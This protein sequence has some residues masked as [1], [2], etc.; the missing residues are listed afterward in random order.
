MK[1]IL[2]SGSA[3]RRTMLEAAGVTFAVEQPN[4]DEDAAK[5]SLLGSGT[6]PR[7]V[8]DALAQLKAVKVSAREPAA[9]VLGSDSVVELADGTML[10]KPTSRQDAA[11]HLRRMSGKR[12]R[13]HSAAVMVE[14]GRPVWREVDTA[15]LFVRPL[16]DA[17]IEAYLDVEWPAI[18]GCV[19][20]FRIEGPGA[21]L[22]SRIDGSQFTVLGLPLLQVLDYLRVRGVLMS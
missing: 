4:V 11:D 14:G 22:F 18:S 17:F 10:D 8:A 7:D 2:A 12:S 3:S 13:L 20:C 21:Q 9:L 1:L 16:S 6:A 5:A 19:G 15:Q